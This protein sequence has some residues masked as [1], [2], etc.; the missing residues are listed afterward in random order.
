MLKSARAVRPPE[1]AWPRTGGSACSTLRR[2]GSTRIRTHAQLLL[3]CK[4]LDKTALH[5]TRL[6]TGTRR[7][8]QQGTGAIGRNV[9]SSSGGCEQEESTVPRGDGL[10]RGERPPR[11]TGTSDV[12]PGP[13]VPHFDGP[14]H[15]H[16]RELE[17]DR[18]RVVD[19]RLFNITEAQLKSA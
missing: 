11:S 15:P 3:R 1:Q 8:S 7:R 13:D 5:G 12:L 18:H 19:V 2:T 6:R 9:G 17:R 16:G 4:G 10:G 14:F